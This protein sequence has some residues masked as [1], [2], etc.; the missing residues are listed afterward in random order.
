MSLNILEYPSYSN[1]LEYLEI[2][3]WYWLLEYSR[4]FMKFQAQSF[5]PNCQLG[6]SWLFLNIQ[7]ANTTKVLP[8]NPTNDVDS[9]TFKNIQ[10]VH[11]TLDILGSF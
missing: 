6:I 11:K 9:R 2:T 8:E 3:C 5:L 4:I 7:A 1:N 10:D